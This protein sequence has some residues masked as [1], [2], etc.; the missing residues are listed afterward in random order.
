MELVLADQVVDKVEHNQALAEILQTL[1]QRSIDQGE[2]IRLMLVGSEDDDIP[3]VQMVESVGG[4]VVTDEHCT[5]T[6]YFWNEVGTGEDPLR[7]LATRY[8]DRPP[9]PSKDWPARNRIPHVL[10]LAKE[11][12]VKG[13]ILI[14]QKFC[15]PHELDNTEIRKQLDAAGVPSLFL[16]L[17]VTVP[18]GQFKVRVEAFVEMIGDEDLFD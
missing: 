12:D 17:D 1:S 15:D 4:V 6:R 3:F 16:E 5:G 9:C 14:Q 11:W 2:G 13:V 18:I 10:S 7:A 8:I